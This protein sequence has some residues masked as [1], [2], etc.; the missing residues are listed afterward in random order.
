[1]SVLT[2][3]DFTDPRCPWAFSAEPSRWRLL[4]LFGDQIRWEPRMV[5][6]SERAD[7][8][9]GYDPEGYSE[10]LRGFVRRYGMP[11]DTRLRPRRPVTIEACRRVVAARLRAP[12]REAALLRRLRVRSMMGELLDEPETVAGA[13]RE[14][15]L[16]SAQLDLWAG[17]PAVAAALRADMAAA[18]SPSS[19]ALALDH[20]LAPAGAGGGRR[21]TCPSYE[22]ERADGARTDSPGFQPLESYEVAIAN[23]APEIERRSDPES[24]GEALAWAGEPLATAEVAAVCGLDRERARERLARAA[25]L[26]PVGNDGYWTPA[27]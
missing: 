10:G 25:R 2:I 11:I 6:L 5:V 14:A 27:G 16:D 24:V 8:D 18:R 21:Y 9:D 20:K 7:P 17:E 22:I 1:M 23:L 12:E 3:R 13:A 19:P 15:G 4:W 26:D